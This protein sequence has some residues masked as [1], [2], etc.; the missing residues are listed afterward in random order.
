M[1]WDASDALKLKNPA[2]RD[3]IFAN[4]E[5]DRALRN[6]GVKFE[7]EPFLG[8]PVIVHPSF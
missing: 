6:R 7:A 3:A 8:Q 1:A 2:N 4:P 5:A